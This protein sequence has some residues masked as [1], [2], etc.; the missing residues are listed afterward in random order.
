MKLK[1]SILRSIIIISIVILSLIIGFVYK[2]VWDKV[3]LKTYPRPERYAELVTKYAE[4]YAVPE[5]LVYAV[6]KNESG[7]DKGF[8]GENGEIGLMGVTFEEFDDMLLITRENLPHDA[9][10][11][12]ET[13]IK[14]GTYQ[15]SLLYNDLQRWGYVCA[16]K[17]AGAEA[18]EG[19]LQDSANFDENGVFVKVPDEEAVKQGEKLLELSEKYR[20][21]YYGN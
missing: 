13:N 4:E 9:L 3:D 17:S 19:W 5:Y 15:L 12:P 6:I 7:F 14:Y 20:E 1:T 16:A 21:M 8:E 2:S 10:Y 11:G 18:A